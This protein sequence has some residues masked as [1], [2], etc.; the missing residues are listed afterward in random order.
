[1]V[2]V[3]GRNFEDA[4]NICHREQLLGLGE[5]LM[6]MDA[7]NQHTR[8]TW[9]E[10]LGIS[11]VFQN[12][13]LHGR[14]FSPFLRTVDPDL[15]NILWPYNDVTLLE[16]HGERFLELLIYK[17][18][19]VLWA[20][21]LLMSLKVAARADDI[22]VFQ[23]LFAL[24]KRDSEFWTPLNTGPFL[25]RTGNWGS[26]KVLSLLLEVDI[27]IAAIQEL[28]LDESARCLLPVL[29]VAARSGHRS[30][31]SALIKAGAP[32]EQTGRMGGTALAEAVEKGHQGAVL[33]LLAAGADVNMAKDRG[34]LNLDYGFG[35]GFTPL[36]IAAAKSNEGMV[37]ILLAAGADFGKD[38][39]D[40]QPVNIAAGK[41]CCGPLERLLSAGADANVANLR[42]RSAL[43]EA[44]FHGHEGAVELLLRHNANVASRCDR[45]HLPC[46]VVSM[47]VLEKRSKDR[48]FHPFRRGRR[49]PSTLDAVDAS[50]ADRIHDML[51]ANAWDRRGWLVM[52][53]ARRLVVAQLDDSSFAESSP[54]KQAAPRH[55]DETKHDIEEDVCAAVECLKLVDAPSAGTPRRVG[56]EERTTAVS[57]ETL[58][59][60]GGHDEGK[61]AWPGGGWECAVEWLLQ[62]PHERGVFR[63]ILSFL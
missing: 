11:C 4:D 7:E 47:G 22:D 50:A 41:G 23:R 27:F 31:V 62:C 44:C 2:S 32:L 19:Y 54:V 35:F 61:Q 20:E 40:A 46:D 30:C 55:G 60:D 39:T 56:D 48:V 21:W 29:A 33:E 26:V 9:K 17:A 10:Q 36:C 42:G 53:H 6:R 63:Q 43:H 1:M 14:R 13:W 57:T 34:P 52:M 38:G 8:K 49:H 5:R 28:E 15:I 16:S 58:M 25:F 24:C 37:D 12:S 59:S 18:P 3:T 45:G 51:R